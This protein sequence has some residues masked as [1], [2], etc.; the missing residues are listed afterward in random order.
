MQHLTAAVLR[1]TVVGTACIL[2]DKCE[3]FW[4]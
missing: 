2:F 1:D 3:G 4:W